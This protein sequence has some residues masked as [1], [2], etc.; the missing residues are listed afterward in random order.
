MAYRPLDLTG[1][2]AVV[3][4]GTSGIGRALTRG[5]AEAGA[6]VVPTRA[7]RSRWP[8]AADEVRPLGRRTL[9][10]TQRRHRPRPSKTRCGVLAPLGRVDILVNCAGRTNARPRLEVGERGVETPSS[11]PTSRVR[12]APARSSA[13][14]CWSAARAHHQHRVAGHVRLPF[15]GRG[16]LREQGRVGS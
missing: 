7:A 10:V 2:V 9:R 11:T 15:R 1:K 16:L 13:G 14:T 12:C 3:T 8:A 4:G 5:L 6:D